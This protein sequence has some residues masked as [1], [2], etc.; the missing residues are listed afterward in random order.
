MR[1]GKTATG[2]TRLFTCVPMHV[3]VRTL[4]GVNPTLSR[5]L[6]PVGPLVL[7]DPVQQWDDLGAGV[8]EAGRTEE[9]GH[10]PLHSTYKQ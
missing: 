1:I 2:A 4:P 6:Q 7:R 10:L 8:Q 9:G 3:P 5:S